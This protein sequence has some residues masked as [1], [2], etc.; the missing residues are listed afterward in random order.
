MFKPSKYPFLNLTHVFYISIVL[1]A[2]LYSVYMVKHSPRDLI[3]TAF[4]L[5]SS[6]LSYISVSA[7]HC[8]LIT[9]LYNF[10]DY[11]CPAL[12]IL[13]TLV[14]IYVLPNTQTIP[15]I[16]TL[17]ASIELMPNII[18]HVIAYS[19]SIYMKVC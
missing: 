3:S 9:S 2:D 4:S 13:N 18:V 7:L 12:N 1:F 19:V 14:S 15:C 8:G 10:F 5:I 16:F 6:S 17:C 11:F